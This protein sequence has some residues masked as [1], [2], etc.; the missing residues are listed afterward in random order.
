MKPD[1]FKDA[2]PWTG[3]AVAASS[4]SDT[5]ALDCDSRG[6][7]TWSPTAKSGCGIR[8]NEILRP[9][10]CIE[11]RVTRRWD[12]AESESI[13]GIY[14]RSGLLHYLQLP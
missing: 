9:C 8:S 3:D 2:L 12:A 5:H 7:S 4:A 6:Q 1:R 13:A 10:I 11:G 14:T